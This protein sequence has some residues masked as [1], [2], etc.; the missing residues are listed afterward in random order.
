M[1]FYAKFFPLSTLIDEFFQSSHVLLS[2]RSLKPRDSNTLIV[3][4]TACAFHFF[5]NVIQVLSLYGLSS[6]SQSVR[7]LFFCIYLEI[8]PQLSDET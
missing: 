6:V 4:P 7:K 3:L 5:I 1:P 8:P 2:F